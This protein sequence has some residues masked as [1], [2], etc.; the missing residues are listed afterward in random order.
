VT[1]GS[2][3]LLGSVGPHG[4]NTSYYFQYGP[5]RA[6]GA[7][8][9]LADAPAGVV[10][11]HAA[12]PVTGLQPLTRYHYRLIAVNAGGATTGV[13]RVFT[14]AKIPLSL[15]ILAA[16]NPVLYGGLVTIQGTLSGTG[17]GGRE[18]VLQANAFPYTAGF[19]NLGNPELTTA[20]GGFLPG[21]RPPQAT[22]FRVVTTT[23][24]GRQ[25]DRRRASR[26]A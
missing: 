8:T 11:V 25:P 4:S 19:A 1:Y 9:G 21:G 17:N 13:D 3:I 23:V 7:Q 5:T 16:P 15:Q 10:T 12:I 2:A 18:V 14:T 20:T 24:P 22:Q 26:C 6:Y